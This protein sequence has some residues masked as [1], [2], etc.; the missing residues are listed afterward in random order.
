MYDDIYIT[1]NK[2]KLSAC[3]YFYILLEMQI[4]KL[5]LNIIVYVFQQQFCHSHYV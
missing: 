4:T 2:I 1:Y 5:I 3:N